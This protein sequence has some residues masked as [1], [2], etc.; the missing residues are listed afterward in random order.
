MDKKPR[1][2]VISPFLD[3]Q[4]GTERCIAEQVERL[5]RDHEVHVYSNRI[6]DV[7]LSR[8]IWHRVPGLPGPHLFAYCWWFIAN[9][10]WRWWDRRFRSLSYDLTYTPGINCFDAD[11][12]SVHILFAELYRRVRDGLSLRKNPLSSWGRLIHRRLYYQLIIGLERLIYRRRTIQLA[13]ISQKTAEDLRRYGGSQ[14]PV[15]YYGVRPERFNPHN[16]ERFRDQNR[17]LLGLP[18]SAFCILFIG[19]DWRNKGLISLLDAVR[20]VGSPNLRLLIVGRDDPAPYRSAVERIGV[21]ECVSFVPL[22]PD[23]EFYYTAADAYVSPVLEDAF[24]LPP[25]EAMACGLPV[26]VSS[27][28]GVSE[29]VSDRID[30]L[31]LKDPKDVGA[32]AAL[33]SELQDHPT[34]RQA[35]GGNAARTASQYTWESNAAQLSAIFEQAI[36]GR[37][38]SSGQTIERC[39]RDSGAPSAVSGAEEPSVIGRH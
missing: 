3:K 24:G 12:I 5:A 34:L 23:V 35:L 37:K 8:I 25:L 7:D 32:L 38:A 19:N 11:V 17:S 15:I 26:I 28:A 13:A 27:R 21:D 1:I 39:D 2:A 20:R 18:E 29:V 30:G 10:L 4:H 33:I 22:R 31:I 6:E 16:R 14:T 36:G 9:H